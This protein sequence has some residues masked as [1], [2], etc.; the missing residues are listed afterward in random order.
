MKGPGV[1]WLRRY[2]DTHVDRYDRQM[3][4][5]DRRLFAGTR[6]WICSGPMEGCWSKPS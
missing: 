3:G 2:W 4:F 5:F 1:E 6:D